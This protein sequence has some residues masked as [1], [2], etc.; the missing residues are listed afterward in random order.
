MGAGRVSL[1]LAEQIGALPW[2]EDEEDGGAGWGSRGPTK[3]M[4]S[5]NRL[6][7]TMGQKKGGATEGLGEGCPWQMGEAQGYTPVLQSFSQAQ[8]MQNGMESGEHGPARQPRREGPAWSRAT[9]KAASWD[10]GVST[11]LRL[12]TATLREVS[13]REW[14]APPACEAST[15]VQDTDVRTR[16]DKLAGR[17]GALPQ[18][19]VEASREVSRVSG[20]RSS[21]QATGKAVPPREYGKD[22]QGCAGEEMELYYLQDSQ[23]EGEIM[24]G[25]SDK[26]EE[27]EEARGWR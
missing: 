16:A 20:T 15:A 21:G 4:Y 3:Y 1:T 7:G 8:R 18:G 22:A 6:A 19:K 26:G 23:E 9:S 25:D 10:L 24:D 12:A 13:R 11:P 2:S 14:A 5:R 17:G 27:Q